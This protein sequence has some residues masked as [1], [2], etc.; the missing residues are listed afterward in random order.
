MELQ[1]SY[2]K[3][4]DILLLQNGRLWDGGCNVAQNVVVYA[5]DD[6]NIVAVEVSGAAGLVRQAIYDNNLT[7]G[8]EKH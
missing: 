6:Q 7:A 2:Y 3:S 4:D 1:I 5:D 8:M